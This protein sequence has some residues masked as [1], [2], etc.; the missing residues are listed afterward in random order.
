M[1]RSP[2]SRNS[3]W[4]PLLLAAAVIGYGVPTTAWADDTSMSTLQREEAERARQYH[5]ALTAAINE[6]PPNTAK[7]EA[8]RKQ[9]EASSN[10]AAGLAGQMERLAASNAAAKANQPPGAGSKILDMALGIVGEALSTAI[11]NW[12]NNPNAEN[13]RRIEELEA[14]RDRLETVANNPNP[15]GAGGSSS[16][17][18]GRPVFDDNGNVIGFDR[19]GDGVVDVTDSNGDGVGDTFNGATDAYADPY[20]YLNTPT[21]TTTPDEAAVA[22]TSDGP[23][24]VGGGGAS[25]GGSFGAGMGGGGGGGDEG[26]AGDEGG[27]GDEELAKDDEGE[28]DGTPTGKDGD[29]DLATSKRDKDGDGRDDV[30][31]QALEMISGR[32][33][34][35]PK[36]DP[37][38]MGPGGA[39]GNRA[40]TGP[41]EDD[42]NDMEDN[43]DSEDDW[44]EDW[45]D[46]WGSEPSTDAMQPAGSGG[47]PAAPTAP[48]ARMGT[49]SETTKLVDQLIRV[50]TVIAEWRKKAKEEA[51]GK[52]DPYGFQDA[53]GYEAGST[54]GSSQ[55]PLVELRGADGKLDLTRCEIWVI[56]RDTWKEGMEP[57]RYQVSV[58]ED[59]IDQFDP[60]NGGYVVVRGIVGAV[61]VETRVLQEIRGDVKK[62]EI[63]QVVLSQEEPPEGVAGSGSELPALDEDEGAA[64]SSGD[65]W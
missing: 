48:G 4:I 39:V 2:H 26:G 28:E 52:N 1:K 59:A 55:D 42:W 36:T 5:A 51:E 33:L 61:P 29:G 25:G 18:T 45:G 64:P 10:R 47:T 37:T 21:P 53:K 58:A 27:E 41:V 38:F 50:E 24:N 32:I 54:T 49:A 44:G 65:G 43:G 19:D 17:G 63:V 46:D 40:P 3:W 16:D 34:V 57:R 9:A 35:M 62:L 15:D 7:I 14:E 23:S 56:E 60:I 22:A 6:N 12:M 11:K 20:E 13:L 30:T 8:L 31:G